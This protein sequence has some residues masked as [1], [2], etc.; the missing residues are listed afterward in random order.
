MNSTKTL[1]VGIGAA[2]LVGCST[3]KP[4]LRTDGEEM[5][6]IYRNALGTD[7][8]VDA[9]LAKLEAEERQ[10]MEEKKRQAGE[11]DKNAKS[12]KQS[13]QSK[14]SKKFKKRSRHAR[15]LDGPDAAKNQYVMG[16]NGVP[17]RFQCGV[18]GRIQD[19]P[20]GAGFGF[21]KLI[22]RKSTKKANVKRKGIGKGAGLVPPSER[23]L[24]MIRRVNEYA[25]RTA[26]KGSGR[27]EMPASTPV[28]KKKETLYSKFTATPDN[29]LKQLFPRLPNPDI[30]VYVTPHLATH[31]RVPVPGYTTAFPLYD[32]VHYAMPGEA[33][34]HD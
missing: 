27:K 24:E 9:R 14:Q 4:V 23:E 3:Y 8:Q 32:Q 1:T 5:L 21:P 11:G 26:R 28:P 13:K 20:C 12:S 22:E 16:P 29:A 15:R 34:V 17:L 19:K 18:G 25:E 33:V 30:V 31:N 10:A 6:D 7:E 2:L